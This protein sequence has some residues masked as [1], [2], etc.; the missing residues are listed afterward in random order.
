MA[1]SDTGDRTEA[2]TPK[3]LERARTSG[4]VAVSR[5]LSTLAGL[6]GAVGVMML[7][8]SALMRDAMARL[9]SLLAGAAS[10]EPMDAMR[11]AASAAL[12]LAGPVAAGV[13]AAS[14]ASVLLQTGFLLS[15]APLAPDLTRISPVAGAKRLFGLSNLVEAGKSVA[16][17]GLLAAA[18][19]QAGRDA[20]PGLAGA[21]LWQA[22]VLADRLMRA[23]LH[24][25]LLLLGAQ[26]V[27]AAADLVWVRFKHARDL[28]MSREEV[29]QEAK[30]SDGNPQVKA[31]L[32]QLRQ[33]RAK[34]R[35]MAA[36]PTATVVVTNPTHYAIALAYDRG[37]GGAPR[38]V[39]KGVD[40]VAARIRDLAQQ[41]RIPLVA[42]PPLA[43]ALFPVELDAEI[44][45]EHFKA[46]A[47][48]IAYVW[49]LRGRAG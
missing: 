21:P 37:R 16:K 22:G 28:K 27:I 4:S 26:A 1:E 5:E 10:V 15:A 32:R 34:K 12:L 44:P 39:A 40:E 14:A 18:A 31:R 42:N 20:L 11:A 23:V 2:A 30:E 25:L 33:A 36:V 43:R 47:E 3:R 6:G 13:L 35:M 41:H 19:W 7:G 38:V 9:A 48:I 46:V 29:K 8:G 17:L 49:R 24:L 45:G